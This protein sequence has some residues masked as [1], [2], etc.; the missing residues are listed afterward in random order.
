MEQDNDMYSCILE[1]LKL[2]HG[3]PKISDYGLTAGL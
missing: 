3:Q 1:L 2:H